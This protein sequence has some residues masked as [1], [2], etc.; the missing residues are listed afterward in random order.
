M[1]LH[2][3]PIVHLIQESSL[4]RM[5]LEDSWRAVLGDV[6]LEIVRS[7]DGIEV[8]F[9]AGETPIRGVHLRW[10]CWLPPGALY[11]NDAWGRSE[12]DL[13]WRTLDPERFLPWFFL[14][15]GEGTTG[16]LGVKTDA[17]CFASFNVDPEGISL[18]L[19]TRN[20]GSG[21]ILGGRRMK[22]ATVIESPGTDAMS[23]WLF[24][25]AF[26][27]AMTVETPAKV[28]HAIYGC[29]NWYYAYGDIHEQSVIE[30]CRRT[31]DWAGETAST[32]QPYMLIDDGWQVAHCDG[33]YNGGP[34]HACNRR[35]TTMGHLAGQMRQCGVRP[36]LWYRPL[37]SLEGAMEPFRIRNDR[38]PAY[39]E[40]GFALD[41]TF[42][43]AAQQIAE[44]AR[45]IADWG[46]ELIKHDF[47]TVDLLG[48]WAFG[49]DGQAGTALP[50]CGWHFHD[51]TRTSAEILRDLYATI[52]RSAHGALILG[53]QTVGHLGVGTLDLQRTGGDVDGRGWARTRRMGPNSLAFRMAHHEI[54]YLVDA[55]CAPIT[56]KL[57][58]ELAL[59]WLDLL[60][61]SGTPLFVSADPASLDRQ[62]HQAIREA[63]RRASARQG[64]AEALD[65]MQTTTPRRWRFGDG[66]QCEYRW[67][68]DINRP[69]TGLIS[70]DPAGC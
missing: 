8:W 28:D 13:G 18:Y 40:G 58:K 54:L 37:V 60:A 23:P 15:H 57:P 62:N 66:S 31:V 11:L 46:F 47:T 52:K 22:L 10:P 17:R 59:Q 7:A 53:C 56:P 30:D 3:K 45:R 4:S 50:A 6:S 42:P 36:G 63:F 39:A 69:P 9:E 19:D 29:N 65:W 1:H 44:D 20:G 2:Q 14:W 67:S 34:W 48:S 12:Y 21:V 32:N 25:R 43:E 55:D 24:A 68:L 16:A 38:K 70:G 5:P 64:P 35:F 27:E 61:R 51:R 33:R 49:Q 41:P 26:A